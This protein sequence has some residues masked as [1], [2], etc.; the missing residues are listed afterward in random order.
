MA[1]KAR[2]KTKNRSHRYGI[3]R[4]RPGYRYKYTKYKMLSQYNDGYMYQATPKQQLKL[5]SGK[6]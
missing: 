4:P 6:C 3:N 2:L 1:T 5:N